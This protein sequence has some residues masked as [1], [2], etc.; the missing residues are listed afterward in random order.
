[1]KRINNILKGA[2]V[3]AFVA[4]TSFSCAP[5][6]EPEVIT[7][8]F[9]TPIEANVEAGEIFKFTI[10][11]NMDWKLN[12]PSEQFALFKLIL[13]NG[14]QDLLQRG[15]AGK[16]E[17]SVLVVD[18]VDFNNSYTCE[19]SL[20]MDNQT[21]VVARLTKGKLQR[22]AEVYMVKY[23]AEEEAFEQTENGDWVY[24][25]QPVTNTDMKWSNSQWM[26]H[27]KIDA[28]FNWVLMG[29]PEWMLTN[30]ITAGERGVTELF[31]RVDSEKWP[32]NNSTCKLD[33]CDVSS[34]TNGNGVV[35]ADDKLIVNSLTLSLEGC[36]EVMD[37]SL[38]EEL[39]LNSEGL[40]LQASTYEYVNTVSGSYVAP[41]GVVL[42]KVTWYND[43]YWVADGVDYSEWLTLTLEDYAE[44]ANAE[45]GVWSRSFSITAQ[46]TPYFTARKCVIFALP[47]DVAAQ[48]SSVTQLIKSDNSD[49]VEEYAQYV[50]T[51][52]TQAG[53]GDEVVKPISVESIDAMRATGGTFEEI[54]SDKYPGGGKWNSIPYGYQMTYNSNNAGS[55]LLFGNDFTRYEIYGPQGLYDTESCWIAIEP[56]EVT[57]HDGKLYRV[58]M[59]LDMGEDEEEESDGKEEEEGKE[60]DEEEEK[61]ARFPNSQPTANGGNEATFVFYDDNDTP[62]ALLHCVLDLNMDPYAGLDELVQFV[63]P[64]EAFAA[65]AKL[66]RIK[67]GDK[68]YDSDAAM[69]GVA[70][71]RLTCSAAYNSV[72]LMVPNHNMIWDTYEQN[73]GTIKAT[74]ISSKKINITITSEESLKG[75]RVTLYNGASDVAQIVIDYNVE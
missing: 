38:A 17:I 36:H 45:A 3:A 58:V 39:K 51:T 71:Y 43:R 67:Q 10:E 9:P 13:D 24:E 60:E 64:Q 41:Y 15:K 57:H 74:Q 48:V 62:Y 29:M 2:M 16:H 5:E 21:Q 30:E 53:T 18:Q 68:E 49:I 12:I 32:L 25:E 20:T 23:N 28:N 14:K 54:S 73:K 7:P 37:W 27:I 52:I 70:T 50:M 8:N 42:H 19:L 33:L 72:E 26:Q 59:R 11:P 69:R 22:R 40:Y 46:P 31:I 75:G 4:V 44:G 47:A 6:P 63:N 55:D 56:S 34:D 1:M 66:E 61:P 65:G 35:D